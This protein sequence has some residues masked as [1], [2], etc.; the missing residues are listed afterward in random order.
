MLCDWLFSAQKMR[1]T[2]ASNV[3]MKFMFQ[4]PFE[5]VKS[6]QSC[7]SSFTRGLSAVF[8]AFFCII[9]FGIPF[10]YSKSRSQAR[11][12]SQA[13]SS[14]APVQSAAAT[15][16]D[17]LSGYDGE[18]CPHDSN[19]QGM[20]TAN[21]SLDDAA[22]MDW[23]IGSIIGDGLPAADL[24]SQRYNGISYSAPESSLVS[25]TT[26]KEETYIVLASSV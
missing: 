21:H 15:A 16:T 23:R 2:V 24:G 17:E 18:D 5:E 19:L 4:E 26:A 10:R 20:D 7:L 3:L 1:G 14:W 22:W 9:T 12:L 6:S 8:T 13:P 11:P 25:F